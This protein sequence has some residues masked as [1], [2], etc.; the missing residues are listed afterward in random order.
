MEVTA[1]LGVMAA[2]PPC[3]E[4][5]KQL[6]DLRSRYKDAS[7]L[8]T[9][10]YSESQV[11][12]ASL[13]QVQTLLDH[14][15][16]RQ[17]PELLETFDR[18]L[19]GCR[20]VYAC[21]EEEVRELVV[22]AENDDLKFRD[23]ARFLWKE[24]TF[25]EL[26]TQIRG[27]QSA[28]SLLVQAL[29]MES[30][31]DIKRL[32]EENSVALEQAVRRSRTLRQSHPKVRIPESVFGRRAAASDDAGNA[33]ITQDAEFTFDDDVVNSKAYRRAMAAALSTSRN[34]TGVNDASKTEILEDESTA[35]ATIHQDADEREDFRGTDTPSTLIGEDAATGAPKCDAKQDSPSQDAAADEHT[36]L[37]DTLERDI[38]AYM[39]RITSTAPQ[40][41]TVP[42][43][44]ES[45]TTP[46]NQDSRQLFPAPLRSFSE[47]YKAPNAI[48]SEVPPPLP[49][50][51]P[52][53]QHTPSE[54]SKPQ[55]RSVS[56][57]DSMYTSDAPSIFSQ[58][59][60]ASSYTLHEAS[61]SS[62]SISARPLRK[63]LPLVNKASYSTL[64]SFG[65][66]LPETKTV[67]RSSPLYN[68]EMHN[69]WS[70][71]VDTE[72]KFID[73]ML[74]LKRVF[75]DNVLKQWPILEKHL[76]A[77]LV[78][79]QIAS[80][81]QEFLLH[82]MDR[83]LSGNSTAV[84]NPGILEA[85]MPHAVSSL[86]TTQNLDQKFAPFVSTL[87]LSITYF[88]MSWED[89]FKLPNL[90]LQSYIASL[91]KLIAIAEIL[92]APEARQEVERLR[93]A[94]QTVNQLSTSTF[95]VLEEAQ[96]REDIQNLE[97]RIR[98]DIGT[99]S[100]LRLNESTRRVKHQGGM[101]MK[102]KSQGPWV[103]VHAILLDHCFLWGKIK[104]SKGDEILITDT[105]IRLVDTEI[106]LP[107]DTHQ[108]QKAT[109]LDQVPRGSTL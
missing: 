105:P 37:F 98:M 47:G 51:R 91:Q 56:S 88:G 92:P 70:S 87:G 107:D 16:L 85:W 18:A 60:T 52:S 59:S 7:V 54:M 73:R 35:L 64:S 15:A 63:P 34:E 25:K 77:I 38:L 45:A 42:S 99:L 83:D 10:I 79:E 39:P 66:S 14:D 74:K 76:G 90:Q 32:V 4:S 84:C 97:K 33:S 101:A 58:V 20:V 19:T 8:I 31:S 9:A 94:V 49:P 48:S 81:H 102:Y 89:Y 82:A 27:Q 103:P 108:F 11:V 55:V 72:R 67:D 106:S 86:R 95:V 22:K 29:Q 69:I 36:A 78:G 17:K 109:M 30:I 26:L 80:V 100:E 53:G 23:R 41:S 6:Y 61:I 71:L 104:K 21:L 5:A 62:P 96:G 44:A 24:D 40:L 93:R 43:R 13:S 2:L 50:R 12:A 65:G 46:Q 75:Y 57:N 1:V 68:S 28:L 3:I